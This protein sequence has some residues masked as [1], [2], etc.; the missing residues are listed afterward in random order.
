MLLH[1]L[2]ML[3][4]TLLLTRCDG[5][6]YMGL[7]SRGGGGGRGGGET[8]PSV[9]GRAADPAVALLAEEWPWS[10]GGGGEHAHR[11]LTTTVIATEVCKAVAPDGSTSA[12]FGK[13][14]ATNGSTTVVGATGDNVGRGMQ[15]LLSHILS[16]ILL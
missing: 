14:V 13:S 1:V 10:A 11:A 3:L 5:N 16:L 2:P 4:L 15:T 6:P 9:A 8:P 12:Y 7:R